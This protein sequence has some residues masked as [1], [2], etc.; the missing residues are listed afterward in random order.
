MTKCAGY[1]RKPSRSSAR[2]DR[3]PHGTPTARVPEPDTRHSENHEKV[4]KQP[5]RYQATGAIDVPING[6]L[7]EQAASAEYLDSAT[8]GIDAAIAR[9]HRQIELLDEYRAHLIA[10]AVT[11]QLA[12]S[13]TTQSRVL[14]KVSR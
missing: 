2:S 11:G 9:A 14:N 8:A 13:I 12:S 1:G 5:I 10:D 4:K 6:P 7:A 3:C